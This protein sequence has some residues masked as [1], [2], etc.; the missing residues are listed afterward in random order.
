MPQDFCK[1]DF[2]FNGAVDAEDVTTFLEHFGRHQYTNPCPPDGPAAVPRTGQ[3]DA[4]YWEDD[5]W[6]EKGVA[7]P[8][9]RF[10]DN[11]DETV[12]DTLTGLMWTQDASLNG[13]NLWSESLDF[14]MA[15]DVAGHEN[16]RLPNVKELLSLIDYGNYSPALPVEHPFSSVAS[17]W[18]YWTSTTS[19]LDTE[20][21]FDV[22][23]TTGT[24]QPHN[25]DF[26]ACIV[27]C[28][29]SGH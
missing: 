3:I 21:A 16:W 2:N 23:M 26:T 13:F 12:T 1:G 28:V 18:C 6:F 10:I 24:L 27:W 11:S 5:G 22:A 19:P 8:N 4:Y 17:G 9:P 29:R 20:D 15:L 25:K 7:Y 14:C